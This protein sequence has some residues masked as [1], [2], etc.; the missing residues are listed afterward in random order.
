MCAARWQG[1]LCPMHPEG[2]HWHHDQVIM[3]Q[4][5]VQAWKINDIIFDC[6]LHIGDCSGCH[7]VNSSIGK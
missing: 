4:P 5:K 3:G 6:I 2:L 1:S 7:I